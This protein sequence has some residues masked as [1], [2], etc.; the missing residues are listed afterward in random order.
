MARPIWFVNI[1]KA[2]FPSRYIFAEMTKIP[3]LGKMV[4]YGL[5]HGDDMYYL[6]KDSTVQ[7]QEN[8]DE[9]ENYILPS[10]I[11]DHFISQSDN[12]WIMNQCICRA[13]DLC[14]DFPIELG[15]IFLGEA[16]LDINPQLGKLVSKQEAVDHAKR[17]RDAGLIHMIGRN[18]LDS[19]WLGVGP[20]AK[21]LTICNC[22]PCCCL[23]RMLPY[24]NPA[25]SMKVN[26]VPGI[27]VQTT[28]QCAGC[29]ECTEGVCFV[30]AIHMNGSQA[31]ISRECRGCGRCIEIC[32][33][34]AIE[35]VIT[36]HYFISNTINQISPLVNI[37]AK[38]DS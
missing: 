36:D 13:S 11:V 19:V 37:S 30:D 14:Q 5:F 23:W 35:L 24:I 32:P 16:V 7:I 34:Q 10:Q 9:V 26:R 21:L 6:P 8:I 29:G 38:Q 18:K 1:L 33:Y 3:I 2:L 31:V 22:C 15:C 25:I 20:S 12:I 17:C 28:D 4:D 27:K